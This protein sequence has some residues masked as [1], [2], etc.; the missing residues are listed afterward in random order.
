MYPKLL[1]L[2]GPLE[3]N[4]YNTA[5][6][7]GLGV[8]IYLANRHPA[9]ARLLS[10]ADFFNVAIE[11]ALAG[12]L[13]GRVLH[14]LSSLQHYPTFL[15]MI[16]IW[17]GG[18]SILGTLFGVL[19]FSTWRLKQLGVPYLAL[20]DIAALYAPLV[21]GIARIGC[22]LVGC[23][24]GAQTDSIFG[25]TY[26][27]PQVLA[28]L[29]VQLHPSQL[30]SSAL[31]FG[32]FFVLW[33]YARTHKKSIGSGMLTLA[34]IMGMSLERFL[35][36]FVR[37]DRIMI[38]TIPHLSFYQVIAA[39]MFFATGILMIRRLTLVTLNESI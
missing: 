37:G 8:F 31:F 36:D 26:T 9:R 14:I 20:A 6:M 39:L 38:A 10:S 7:I 19:A 12:I 4:S 33:S 17:D 28:P 21:H 23:C 5:I 24:Y 15:S 2:Y 30:Y 18:L 32:L 16:S 35:V 3:L 27:H 34:Y 25:I 29:H 1:T 11:S 22:F 13:G